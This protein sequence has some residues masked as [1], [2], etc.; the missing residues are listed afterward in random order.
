MLCQTK[1]ISET[2]FQIT[3]VIKTFPFPPWSYGPPNYF[4]TR[5][6]ENKFPQIE[7]PSNI[8]FQNDIKFIG[9]REQPL[10]GKHRQR[11]IEFDGS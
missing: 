1:V 11:I 5:I 3:E 2:I 7:F 9:W 6:T 10:F 4:I 8:G